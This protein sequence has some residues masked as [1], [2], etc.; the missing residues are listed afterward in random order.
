MTTKQIAVFDLDGTLLEGNKSVMPDLGIELWKGGYRRLRGIPLF[1]LAVGAGLLRKLRLIS[2]ERYTKIGT[3]LIVWWMAGASLADVK[4]YFLRTVEK[5]RIRQPVVDLLRQHQAE[6]RV[7]LLV[8]AVIQPLL[9]SFADQIGGQALGTELEMTPDGRLTGRIVEP[10]CSGIGKVKRLQKWESMS[11]HPIDWQTSYAYGDTLPDRFMLEAVGYPVA[12][13]PSDDLRA[14]A[15]RRG[16]GIMD[17]ES[18]V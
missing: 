13:F 1:P 14:E 18:N 2:T 3:R 10:L 16:W 12:V 7:T 6:G 11:D 17:T 15:V 5:Q 4:P 9:E 8:S